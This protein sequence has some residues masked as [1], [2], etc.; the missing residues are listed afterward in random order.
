MKRVDVKV[1]DILAWG[2]YNPL[3]YGTIPTP[4]RVDDLTSTDAYGYSNEKGTYYL[5]T[6]LGYDLKEKGYGQQRF[7]LRK[8]WCTWDSLPKGI[9]QKVAEQAWMQEREAEWLQQAQLEKLRMTKLAEAL[10]T[11]AA[12]SKVKGLYQVNVHRFAKPAKGPEG[13][14][15]HGQ[16]TLIVREDFLLKFCK[17]ILND[18][19]ASAL[20]VPEAE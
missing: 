11:L 2:D 6:M 1:G 16:Y 7:T 5:G 3:E 10:N 4:I 13:K 18:I 17:G 15:T 8:S 9:L 14:P 19:E 20:S 12:E